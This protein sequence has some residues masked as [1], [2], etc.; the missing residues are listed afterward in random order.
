MLVF[1]R[2]SIF[3]VE[4]AEMAETWDESCFNWLGPSILDGSSI[5]GLARISEFSSE[6]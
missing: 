2:S 6:I 1:L 5:L 3:M 4:A